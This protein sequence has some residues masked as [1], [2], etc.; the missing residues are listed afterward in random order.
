MSPKTAT[1]EGSAHE[2]MATKYIYFFG[3]GS[4][5]GRADMKA[6]LGGKGANLAEM[7][8]AGIPVPPGFTITTEA[9]DQYYRAGQSWPDGLTDELRDNVARLEQTLGRRF[10][11]PDRP[12]LVSVRSG[13]AMSMP[14]MMDTVLNLGIN[15]AVVEGLIARTGNARWAWDCYRR[16]IDMFG[17]VVME[18]HHDH[19]EEALEGL[20][21][22]VGA[23]QDTDLDADQLAELVRRYKAVYQAHIGEMFPS[24]PLD[25]L[26]H[27][28][29]AVFGSWNSARALKY[30]E[31]NK[32]RGLLGTA[33]NVQTMVF[34][35]MGE[36]SGTG[37][38]FT[39][40]P[41]NGT[42]V[43]YGEYLINAQG[44]DVVAGIRTA[45]PIATLHDQMPAVYDQLEAIRQK[46]E[47]HYTDM[48]DLEFTIQDGELFILQ[49]RN[50][51][52][53]GLAAIKIAVEMVAE[54]LI[55]D[56]TAVERVEPQ[57]ISQ[58]L[59][60]YF[61]E[62]ELAAARDAGRTLGRG[63]P[64]GP[65]AA[66]GRVV[67]TADE[68]EEWVARGE[69]VILVRVET[70]PEDVGGMYAAEGI[71]TSRGGLTSHAAVV[72]R[73]WGKCCVSGS[74]DIAIDY[75]TKQFTARGTVIREG[76]VIALN[77]WEGDFFA[78][79]IQV[80][81]SPV[82]RAL[83]DQDETAQQEEIYRLYETF[84]GWIE[85]Y[86][87]TGVR[88]NADSPTDA[89]RARA[90]GAEGIGLCRTAP[91]VLEGDRIISV[92]RMIL[93][94]EQVKN[95]KAKHEVETVDELLGKLTDPAELAA[96][97]QFQQALAELLPLQRGDFAGIFAA[98]DGLPVT[99]RLLDPPLHEF[100]PHEA[101]NQAEMAA[102]MGISVAEV[103]QRVEALHEFNPMLG[104]RG[105]RLSITYPE[106]GDMQ[107]RAILEAACE[108]KRQG[109]DA[110]PEIMIP[111]VGVKAEL[112]FLAER[113]HATAQAVF[114]E[115]GVE[116][117]YLVGT[118]IEVPR[119]AVTA[120]EIAETAQFF[121]FGTNDLTQMGFGFSRDDAGGFIQD[122]VARKV[123][124]D[125]P[126]AT[127]DIKGIG[128]LIQMGVELGRATR[129]DLK[130]G[131]C[132]EHGGDPKSVEFC[133]R[134]GMNYVSCSPFRVTVARLAAAQAAV[135]DVAQSE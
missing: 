117:P 2:P 95:L 92:R 123:L 33:V 16:F 112:D 97:Q 55:T 91:M 43:F 60:P 9:C 39:R 59:L 98:M 18:V 121:S 21:A 71:L 69:K 67:F 96:A 130:V 90:V 29:D 20:K 28:I 10:G 119:A 37:V 25:Q 134:V 106:I 120:D 115:Q 93:V 127:L 128:K 54:G 72:A 5:E 1:R 61:A 24:D 86:R 99:I 13:A 3:G 109:I 76:D 40:D 104:H 114:A 44:E 32:I 27:S 52:R 4:A 14:G 53:T 103:K 82:V 26:R 94:A 63:L 11:D 78:G 36:T 17:D 80:I 87:T 102:Q 81:P 45:Q 101:E 56:K 126:F 22:E 132:G 113:C 118:M 12:L 84:N 51:K 15:D 83:L 50:G 66:V 23:V 89:Q 31:I 129:P 124:E 131:I 85:K 46:L 62:T 133:C 42:R 8:N 34:G 100:L 105:C 73:Q 79:E 122:Y 135:G 108:C 48:Q 38:A 30:R 64:A 88:T 49:T 57:H 75:A 110:H 70:S 77:G 107:V 116:V 68:A 74:E 19:F 6:L 111:L 41:A 58:L 47:Q 7:T 65:G 125:D 35:N